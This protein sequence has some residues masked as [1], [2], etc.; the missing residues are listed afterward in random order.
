MPTVPV[1]PTPLSS[2]LKVLAAA[3]LFSS[4]GA[5]IKAVH[6]AGWQV[7]CLRSAIAA[8]ALLVLVR[9]V[10]RRPNLRVLAVGLAYAS[11]MILFVLANKL[12]TAAGAIYLQ[13]TAPLY[14]LLLSP[15]LLKEPI[16]GR[17]VI[18]MVVL[19]LGLGLF[20]VGLD[21][22]SATAPNPL[23]GNV[24]SL[25]SGVTWALTIM[26]LRSLGRSAGEGSWA[27][28]SAFWGNVFAALA[29]LPLALPVTASRPTDWVILG[30]LGVFQIAIAYLVLLR[31]LE[32]VGAFE[33]SLLLLLEPVLNPIW[34]WLVHGERPGAWSLAGG[35]VII[36]ATVVK[37][38]VDGRGEALFRRTHVLP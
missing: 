17:D 18:Y 35:G 2:R 27:P 25:V 6:L 38:W 16:R 24:L 9:E 28:A 32:R 23:L 22:V 31:G 5:A 36:F 4:G 26:G 11:T 34:A 33:A 29:C 15:W 8:L 21:P 19:A 10:R 13:S 1:S 7:A 3:A 37:S 12:T 30:Y 14:V 20:F